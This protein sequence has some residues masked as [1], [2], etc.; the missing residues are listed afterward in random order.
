ML[1]RALGQFLDNGFIH[2]VIWQKAEGEWQIQKTSITIIKDW[3]RRLPSRLWLTHYGSV[4]LEVLGP[5]D[6]ITG[7]S[8]VL[9]SNSIILKKRMVSR[10]LVLLAH[11]RP[12][13]CFI[14]GIIQIY[15]EPCARLNFYFFEAIDTV[16]YFLEIGMLI[17]YDWSWKGYRRNVFHFTS[18][19]EPDL[20]LFYSLLCIQWNGKQVTS[21]LFRKCNLV[22]ALGKLSC[23]VFILSGKKC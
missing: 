15:Q 6:I 12:A 1:S 5:K 14:A 22:P 17:K 4:N 2:L 13:A 9:L 16:G 20:T 7:K 10:S 19:I 8:A 18:C 3:G 23:L 21:D 11:R